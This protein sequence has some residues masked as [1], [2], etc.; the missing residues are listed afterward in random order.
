MR[1]H[2]K[3][4]DLRPESES[5]GQHPTDQAL[6]YWFGLK[7]PLSR[8]ARAIN[9]PKSWVESRIDSLPKL[10]SDPMF[11]ITSNVPWES[12]TV[13]NLI[14]KGLSR[15]NSAALVHVAGEGDLTAA[16]IR[17]LLGKI[18]GGLKNKGIGKGDRVAV[19][20]SQR[21]ETYLVTLAALL[22]GATI[23]RLGDAIGPNTLR[24]MIKAAPSKITFSDQLDIIGVEPACGQHVF[25]SDHATFET[26]SSFLVDC[27]AP[28]TDLFLL[29]PKVLPHDAAFIGFTTGSS[30]EPKL[31]ETSHEAVFRSTEV[32]HKKFNFQKDDV[33]CSATDFTA[34]SSFR[35]LVTLPFISGGR[36]VIPD[37]EARSSPLALAL[38]CEKFSVTRLT[39]VP[40]VL[41]TLNQAGDRC[42]SI[43]LSS[44]RTVFCGSGVL[45]DS[46][47]SEFGKRFQTPVVDY[48]GAR[49]F[50][51]AAYS[52]I[53]ADHTIGSGGGWLADCLISIVNQNGE[54]LEA[55]VIGEVMV[56]SD[57]M[58]LTDM[59][60]IHKDGD[61]SGW[62]STGDLGRLL[63]DGRLEIVGRSKEV[64]KSADGSL[65]HPSEI[66]NVLNAQEWVSNSSAFRWVDQN[67]RESCAVALVPISGTSLSQ[68]KIQIERQAKLV[69]MDI[70]GRFKVPSYVMI[71]DTLPLLGRGKPDIQHLRKLLSSEESNEAEGAE[72]E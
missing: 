70:L 62:H 7:A 36:V 14:E 37:Q 64:V 10:D 11:A 2:R 71:M 24:S 8:I 48:Y 21:F 63:I 46:T 43:N 58:T 59:E 60:S 32:A 26:F 13:L 6:L 9:R 68:E 17:L 45:D 19:D 33:F 69:I 3:Y 29:K 12:R 56:H 65:T 5:L 57:C 31:M 20:S 22:L 67:G 40:N 39:V 66:E 54:P 41:R 61:W 27:P 30:G 52:D 23:V 72:R 50:A 1:E 35:S 49:E 25:L 16:D 34:L 38:Q 15:E 42:D 51:T 28:E 47:S 55:N 18:R 4:S 44:L 53:D